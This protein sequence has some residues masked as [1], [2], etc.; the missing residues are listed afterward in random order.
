MNDALKASFEQFI[1]LVHREDRAGKAQAEPQ[2]RGLV[3]LLSE[4]DRLRRLVE[5]VESKSQFRDLARATAGFI[6]ASDSETFPLETVGPKTVG[7]G[8]GRR[9]H[10]FF[11]QRIP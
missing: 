5:Q 1:S 7:G 9:R 2:D 11:L 6:K 10:L 8:R 3:L 4:E